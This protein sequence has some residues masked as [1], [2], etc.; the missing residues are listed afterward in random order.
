ML[1]RIE[2][3]V[4]S[5]PRRAA[6]DTSVLIAAAPMPGKP[7]DPV[8]RALLAAL[9]SNRC[10]LLIPA[11]AAAE[12]YRKNSPTSL[13]VLGIEVVPFDDETARKV[14]E[15][16]PPNVIKQESVASGHPISF[17]KYDAMIVAC[18]VRH[19]ADAVIATDDRLLKL[20]KR[21]QMSSRKPFEFLAKQP[22][23]P[24]IT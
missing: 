18:A 20:C 19:R 14:G 22:A 24:H 2:F 4:A 8:S 21:V 7:A 11:P 12:F 15:S 10:T 23:L 16:F 13:H 5:L 1:E 6:I 9:L 3:D 17:M